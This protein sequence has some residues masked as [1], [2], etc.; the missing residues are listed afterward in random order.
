M[1]AIA[2]GS[3]VENFPNIITCPSEMVALSMADGYARVTGKPQAV[4]VHV[5]VG[6]QALGCAVHNA[7]IARSPVLIF[8]GLCPATIEG[9]E[10]G[11]RTEFVNFLQDIPDQS[12]VVRQYCRY[13]NEIRSSKNVKQM[14]ARAL[15]FSQST[16]KGPVYL[17]AAREILE[18]EVDPYHLNQIY[19]QPVKPSGLPQDAI[20]EIAA[21]L[22]ASSEP[23]IITGYSGRDPRV[24]GALVNLAD[25]VLGLRVLDT[26]L[27]DV[28]FPANHPAWLGGAYSHHASIPTA[29]FILV[30]DC[31]VPWVPT[32]GGPRKDAVIYHLDVDPL[33]A[34]IAVHYIDAVGRWRVDAYTSITQINAHVVA[35]QRDSTSQE[36]QGRAEVLAKCRQSSHAALLDRIAASAASTSKNDGLNAHIIASTL[37]RTCPT[38]SIWC[39]E[40]VTNTIPI[41][42]QLQCTSPGSYL[43][44]G[45]TGLGWAGGA[46][47]GIKMA[48]MISGEN[49]F[50]TQIIGDGTYL[51]SHPSS[52]YWISARYSIPILVV[53][54]KNKGWNAPRVSMELVHP[55]GV[56]SRVSN[57]TLAISH[58]NPNPDLAGIAKA[59][60]GG[61]IFTGQSS[62]VGELEDL[63]PKAIEAVLA[64]NTAVVECIIPGL[65]GKL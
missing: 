27:G 28:C 22:L 38:S 46:S 60:S 64:G 16:P 26:S 11:S 25:R 10:R 9:E 13:V 1:E 2:K 44:S 48:S 15:Q 59:A 6:T 40:A 14:V 34:S 36:Q 49:R 31:D 21:A 24:P 55:S 37:K 50:V 17:Y 30:L 61:S 29:D 35:T 58:D 19:W 8:A 62:T 43:S 23:L 57:A 47:L 63:L 18:R 65:E 39:V 42:N 20:E 53:I 56:G 54:L 4:I 33:K 52:V 5:D 12:A 32:K 7:H 45:A 41:F 3:S 51:F